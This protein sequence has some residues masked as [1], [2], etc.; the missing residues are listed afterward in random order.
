MAKPL[1]R[2]SDAELY[3]LL[4]TERSEEAFTELYARHSSMVMAYCLRVLGTTD[5]AQDAFQET[6]LRFFNSAEADRN[7][8]NV[9]GYLIRIARN[10]CLNL[11][12]DERETIPLDEIHMPIQ[13]QA[14][15]KRELLNLITTALELLPFEYRE[16]FVLR[17]YNGFTFAEIAEIVDTSIHTV[18]IRVYRA[19]Q[20]LRAIL[21]RYLA[22][23]EE[24]F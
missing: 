1:T 2:Y 14:P 17:M 15:E 23:I 10:H 3:A 24:Q 16:A 20:K 8:T 6:F 5:K 11:I 19:K 9:Q 13:E 18:K 21:A 7:M 12:R 4:S 22:D